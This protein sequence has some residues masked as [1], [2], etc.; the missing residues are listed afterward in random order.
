MTTRTA[1][2]SLRVLAAG[3]AAAAAL[4]TVPAQAAST[5]VDDGADASASLT[6]IRRVRVD[7]SDRTV[8]VRVGFPNLRKRARAGLTV[9]FDS[10]PDARGPERA[11]GLPLFSGSDY[12]MW[13]MRDWEYVGD[14]PV[15]CRYGADYR[16]RRD[17]LVLTARRGCFDRAD[18][19]RVGMRMRDVA[20]GSHPVTDW[21]LGRRDFTEW[22]ASGEP[23]A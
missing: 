10:D 19:V 5:V 2:R 22:V 21:L 20:D 6:D 16:W 18:E 7:H 14:R 1:R 4:A 3:T 15:G 23:A 9:Y 8:E 13:R 11:V 17:V 12:V